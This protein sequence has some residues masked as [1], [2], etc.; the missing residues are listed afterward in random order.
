MKLFKSP[1]TLIL[2]ITFGVLL[3]SCKKE[4][5]KEDPAPAHPNAQLVLGTWSPVKYI[6]IYSGQTYKEDVEPCTADDMITLMANGTYYFDEGLTKCS[7]DDPQ[8]F[9][10]TYSVSEDGNNITVDG[11]TGKLAE[12]TDS[13]MV[14]KFNLGPFGT[15]GTEYKKLY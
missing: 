1:L 2:V 3:F 8:S 7:P 13:T 4:D 10:K 6:T 11:T 15:Q 5:K 9:Q 12:L 14:I